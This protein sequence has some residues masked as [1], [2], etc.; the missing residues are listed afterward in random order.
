[1]VD[2]EIDPALAGHTA[3][4]VA[5]GVV[6]DQLLLTGH[7]KQL[8]HLLL[9]LA[10][11]ARVLVLLGR[12]ALVLLGD[13][14]LDRKIG[15]RGSSDSVLTCMNTR[16]PLRMGMNGIFRIAWISVN[17]TMMH[18]SALNRGTESAAYITQ[19]KQLRH[20]LTQGLT[21][22]FECVLILGG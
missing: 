17:V 1:M 7:A 20:W 3:L 16:M 19:D 18:R 5:T 10:E 22:E 6:V 15:G 2:A 13:D 12:F 4:P 8:P 9:G 14:A 11:L 21:I